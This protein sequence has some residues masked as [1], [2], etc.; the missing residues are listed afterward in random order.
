MIRWEA[1]SNGDARAFLT[2]VL[3]YVGL[4]RW[5]LMRFEGG[6]I[7][8][9]GIDDGELKTPDDGVEVAEG[10]DCTTGAV[11]RM[12]RGLEESEHLR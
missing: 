10:R 12:S 11:L 5:D 2:G 9:V 3:W 8:V 1:G 6:N 7:W 4:H